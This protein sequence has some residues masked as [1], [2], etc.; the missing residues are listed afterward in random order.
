MS[1]QFRLSNFGAFVSNFYVAF[2]RIKFGGFSRLC[3]EY[4]GFSLILKGF[5]IGHQK[6]SP[7]KICFFCLALLEIVYKKLIFGAFCKDIVQCTLYNL[8]DSGS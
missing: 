3:F 4:F 1:F 6:V 7:G 5:N 2:L 8:P